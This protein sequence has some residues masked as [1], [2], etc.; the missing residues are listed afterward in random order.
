MDK[1]Q[2]AVLIAN[3]IVWEEDPNLRG[4]PRATFYSV[5]KNTKEV[6]KHDLPADPYSL[7]LYLKRGF[8]LTPPNVGQEPTCPIC[9]R[10]CKSEF[11]LKAHMRSHK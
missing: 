9:G 5:N 6:V 4:Q 10:T 2:V 1:K 11:G 3:G 8:T 7:N